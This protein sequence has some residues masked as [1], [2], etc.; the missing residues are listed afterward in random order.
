MF[1]QTHIDNHVASEIRRENLCYRE[2][3]EQS[4]NIA[5]GKTRARDSCGTIEESERTLF[6]CKE[7][8][9]EE[10]EEEEKDLWE[11][12]HELQKNQ[13]SFLGKGP[14]T[15]TVQNRIQTVAQGGIKEQIEENTIFTPAQQP[16]LRK[17]ALPTTGPNLGPSRQRWVGCH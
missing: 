4:P 14:V 16:V 2:Y 6:E 9:E 5:N 3:L 1:A 10:E 11:P 12:E 15:R 13:P 8:E 7:E 17:A